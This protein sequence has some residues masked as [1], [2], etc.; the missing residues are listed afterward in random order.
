MGLTSNQFLCPLC[1]AVS[2]THPEPHVETQTPSPDYLKILYQIISVTRPFL[3]CRLNTEYWVQIFLFGH[4][5]SIY[6]SQFSLLICSLRIIIIIIYPPLN[7]AL[8]DWV[9]DCFAL[10]TLQ[11][12]L[13]VTWVSVVSVVTG[14]SIDKD[15]ADPT[16]RR[17]GG[18]KTYIIVQFIV[19]SFRLGFIPRTEGSIR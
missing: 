12:L 2:V 9:K 3:G 5:N 18:G 15:T 17:G 14:S 1:P 19:C 8:C 11:L 7:W 16:A 13:W 6:F 10:V 4:N